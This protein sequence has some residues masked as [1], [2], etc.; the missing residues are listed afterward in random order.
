MQ[1]EGIS[2]PLKIKNFF[3]WETYFFPLS[4]SIRLTSV[5]L[6]LFFSFLLPSQ[7]NNFN[8]LNLVNIGN[9]LL[10]YYRRGGIPISGCLCS[11]VLL[12]VTPRNYLFIMEYT[13]MNLAHLVWRERVPYVNFN[14]E[15]FRGW[16]SW[17]GVLKN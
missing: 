15:W 7:E 11:P 5:N 4:S 17:R 16:K 3:S 12:Q 10:W 1:F 9:I 2:C 13:G 8:R 14:R 6:I